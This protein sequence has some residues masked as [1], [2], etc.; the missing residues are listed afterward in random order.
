MRHECNA[1]GLYQGQTNLHIGR[2]RNW[3]LFLLVAY[4]TL[5]QKPK[6]TRKGCFLLE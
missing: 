3:N 1:T 2:N 6:N 5:I 4:L